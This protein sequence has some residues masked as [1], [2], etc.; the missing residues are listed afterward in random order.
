[1]VQSLARNE[2]GQQIRALVPFQHARLDDR[3]YAGVVE[4]FQ[5]RDFEELAS[6]ADTVF[7]DAIRMEHL[8]EGSVAPVVRD[9][10]GVGICR[11]LDGTDDAPSGDGM[12]PC[13][14]GHQ[15]LKTGGCGP[16]GKLPSPG[17]RS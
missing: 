12:G 10:V 9:P 17:P 14:D 4:R 16:C 8:Q 15:R 1:M 2:F 7:R 3:R 6:S 13:R 5:D 11:L